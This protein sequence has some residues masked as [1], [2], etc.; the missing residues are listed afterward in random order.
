MDGSQPEEP[1]SGGVDANHC[2]T[3]WTVIYPLTSSDILQS[4]YTE[5][6]H[7]LSIKALLG[8]GEK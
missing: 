1:C 3:A 2:T 8:A 6:T 4:G 7:H 5:P